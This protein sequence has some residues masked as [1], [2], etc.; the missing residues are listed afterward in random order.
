VLS[1]ENLR[2]ISDNCAAVKGFSGVKPGLFA[3]CSPSE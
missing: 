3:I 2:R 1:K